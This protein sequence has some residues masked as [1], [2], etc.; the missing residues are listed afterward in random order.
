[1]VC[2]LW[3]QQEEVA[4]CLPGSHEASLG[5]EPLGPW[6]P[7]SGRH[8][9]ASSHAVRRVLPRSATATQ[10]RLN[11]GGVRLLWKPKAVVTGGL[12]WSAA[13]I[14]TSYSLMQSVSALGRSSPA[15]V[16]QQR[17]FEGNQETE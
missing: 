11:S 17:R 6:V 12:S 16:N 8:I 1:M 9:T 2:I 5:A 4:P 13:W 15:G 10:C 7:R 3:Q 14:S